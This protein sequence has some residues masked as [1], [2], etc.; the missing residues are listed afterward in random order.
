MAQEDQTIKSHYKI[1]RIGIKSA[2]VEDTTSH[3]QQ[4][5]A[6]LEEAQ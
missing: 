1:I 5:L 2:V 4:T 6:L 3:N